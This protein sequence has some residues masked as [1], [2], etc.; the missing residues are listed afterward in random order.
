LRVSAPGSFAVAACDLLTPRSL[1]PQQRQSFRV[2]HDSHVGYESLQGKG[3]VAP[4]RRAARPFHNHPLVNRRRTGASRER[5]LLL[6]GQSLPAKSIALLLKKGGNTG[7]DYRSSER[8]S[9]DQKSIHEDKFLLD[10]IRE[11][12]PLHN[13]HRRSTDRV[14]AGERQRRR[15]QQVRRWR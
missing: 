14:R 12:L 1:G 7:F 13:R 4:E 10:T 9:T 6:M 5:S 3:G 11:R 15:R 2:G 8:R